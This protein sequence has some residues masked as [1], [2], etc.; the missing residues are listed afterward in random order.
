MINTHSTDREKVAVVGSG[1]SGLAA[2]YL[3]QQRHEVH[4]FEAAPRLGGHANTVS[5]GPKMTPVDTGFIVFNEPCYPHLTAFFRHLDVPIADSEMSLSVRFHRPD[6][7]WGGT[8]LATLVAQ[9]RNLVRP[10]FWS[11]LLDILKFHRDAPSDL[12]KSRHSGWTIGDFLKLKRFSRGFIDWYLI[13]MSAAIWSSPP[14]QM[15]EYPAET[16]LQ[17]CLN[18]RLLQVNGRPQ[19]K[20]VLGGSV[21]YVNRVAA[22]LG[23]VHLNSPVTRATRTSDGVELVV[24]GQM[25]GKKMKFD[26]VVFAT[27]APLTARILQGQSERESRILSSFTFQ[28]NRAQLHSDLKFMPNRKSLWSSWNFHQQLD[29]HSGKPVSLSYWMNR[30]QPL[31]TDTNLIVTLNAEQAPRGQF[32][33]TVYHHPVFNKSAIAAQGELDSIQGEGGVFYAG[34]WTRYGFHEDG[35]LSAVR[36]AKLWGISTPWVCASER[37]SEDAI[38]Q[39]I[40]A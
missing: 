12:E 10:M 27:H 36:L 40:S 16:F 5:V 18:H 17:F 9:R 8:S 30:L 13:P 28:E 32:Y 14:R 31:S 39:M 6:L 25:G 26:A 22:R 29:T 35:I 38:E 21:E 15:L 4:L 24:E 33:E 2:A 37:K 1:I 20:T 19:W 7:E 11:M 34:A 3:L 23:N